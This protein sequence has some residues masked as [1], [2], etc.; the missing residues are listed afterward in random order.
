[1]KVCIIG[2]GLSS[3][4][5]AKALVNQKIYV[6][7]ISQKKNQKI[8][9]SRTLGISKSN[10]EFFNKN[11]VNIEKLLWKLNKIE[12]YT[13]NLKNEKLLNFENN[14]HEIF[15]IIKNHQLYK[16]LEKDLSKNKFF[17]KKNFNN[18][19]LSFI[20]NFEIIINCDY[21]DN[22]T[23]KYFSKKIIKKYDSIAYTTT[24]RHKKIVNN[25]ASQIF[26]KKGPLAFLPISNTETSI[27]YSVHNSIEVN[28]I[29]AEARKVADNM[30][31]RVFNDRGSCL[32][33]VKISDTIMQGVV[34]IP[35]G[36]WLDPLKSSGL[37]CIHGNPNVLT[38][39]VGTSKLAQGPT[40]HTCLVE[41]K[42]FNEETPTISAFEPPKITNPNK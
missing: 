36:A 16:V 19:N 22:F 12:I 31:V 42:K 17:K 25:V 20:N 41:I 9:P 34:N 14:N 32:A 1:M 40:A 10:T 24:I 38:K 28:K 15:S 37:S 6:E 35:T 7:L 4:T 8:N 21:L 2:N 13:D 3:L 11:I 29:D 30:V 33:A 18:R 26:T 39:D 27:V 5:L 23:N